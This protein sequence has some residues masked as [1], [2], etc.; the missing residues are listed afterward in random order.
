MSTFDGQ[1]QP[2]RQGSSGALAG[3]WIEARSAEKAPRSGP[4]RAPDRCCPRC[5]PCMPPLVI[6]AL[7]GVRSPSG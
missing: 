7:T 1:Q 5:L 2:I 6:L 4:R 3:H